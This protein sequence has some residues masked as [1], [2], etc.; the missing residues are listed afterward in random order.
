V[1]EGSNGFRWPLGGGW[2]HELHVW[3]SFVL[4][5]L[6]ALAL[7]RL[8]RRRSSA[9]QRAAL[10]LIC[11]ALVLGIVSAKGLRWN[12]LALWAVSDGD[13]TPGIW[14]PAF[15]DQVRF[16]LIQGEGEVVPDEYRTRVVGHVL[17]VPALL[18]AAVGLAWR[19]RGERR[20][21]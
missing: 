8:L 11:V 17:A 15:D 6:A 13:V 2:V 4:V 10:G 3:S 12:A 18:L 21:T 14:S 7:A 9:K 5:A 1:P 20:A 19:V 16:I